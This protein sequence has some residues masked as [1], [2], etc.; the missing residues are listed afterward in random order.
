MTRLL[1]LA[2]LG[3]KPMTG[4]DIKV[5]LEMND[6]E[7]WG[8]VLIGSIYNALKKLEKDGYIEVASIEST[9]HRQKAI[10]QITEKGRLY[11][12]QLIIEALEK[13]SVVYPTTLYSGVSFAFKLP[14]E[15]AIRALEKQQ[16]I[17][18]DEEKAISVGYNA[19][20]N[21]MQ[22]EIPELTQLAFDNMLE[23]VKVQL[24]FVQQAIKIMQK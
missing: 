19:K 10:Y 18:E 14:N 4:Y 16:K 11:E 1:V 3:L 24:K 15:K 8:G 5:M 17:L 20:M 21:A 23:I 9:G 7:R 2:M 13:S 22:G 6:A 12:Q